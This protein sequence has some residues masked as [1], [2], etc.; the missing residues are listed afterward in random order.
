M[1]NFAN[2]IFYLCTYKTDDDVYPCKY[3][4]WRKLDGM[5]LSKKAPGWGAKT[6]TVLDNA[7]KFACDKDDIKGI[8]LD[9]GKYILQGG[10]EPLKRTTANHT[11]WVKQYTS[12]VIM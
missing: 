2:F 11:V 3:G 10:N 7:M 6:F 8:Y 12:V 1:A 9:D 4:K 5:T